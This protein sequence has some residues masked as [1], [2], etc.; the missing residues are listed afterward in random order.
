VPAAASPP[1]A[2][3]PPLAKG[4]GLR[5]SASLSSAPVVEGDFIA[6]REVLVGSGQ[7]RPVRFLGPVC[8]PDLYKDVVSTGSAVD[9]ARKSPAGFDRALAAVEWLYRFGY[10]EPENPPEI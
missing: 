6:R 9:A 10:L 1:P 4:Q 2:P 5:G 3:R 8:L 7:E